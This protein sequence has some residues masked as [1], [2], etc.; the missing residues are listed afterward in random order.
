MYM[1]I[2]IYYLG[3]FDHD[4]TVRPRS[5]NHGFDRDIIPFYGRKIQLSGSPSHHGFQ[6]FV[7][8]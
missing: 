2:Y 5:G 8:I 4:L 6:Y 1:N 7:M 3:K